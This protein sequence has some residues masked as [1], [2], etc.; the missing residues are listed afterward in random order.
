MSADLDFNSL[1]SLMTA[2]E[3]IVFLQGNDYWWFTL[4]STDGSR[5]MSRWNIGEH[6]FRGANAD[7]ISSQWFSYP[8]W[9]MIYQHDE[10]GH[11]THGS[12]SNLIDAVADGHRVKVFYKRSS[13]EADE[14]RFRNGHLCISI[15][16]DLSRA[17]V[18]SFQSSVYWVW[19]QI[20]TTG[21]VRTV[22]Y[23]VGSNMYVSGTSSE[24]ENITWFVDT[25]EWK[26]VLITAENGSVSAGS[27]AV[28]IHALRNGAELR[29]RTSGSLVQQADNVA[30]EGEDVGAMHVRS[31]SVSLSGLH[32]VEFNTNPYWWFTITSTRGNRDMSRW[33][34]GSHQ[35]RGHNSDSVSV[36]WFV[37]E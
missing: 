30:I 35:T 23:K 26:K 33:T 2:N 25:R 27:K 29:Y 17:S 28:L 37:S 6:V 19:R 5:Q 7:T 14:V 4:S 10:A 15:L 20:C 18:D 8:C 31:I 34:V 11:Q 16:N 3:N 13:L 9:K 22:R 36:E 12:L 32:E 1:A 24:S 21:T